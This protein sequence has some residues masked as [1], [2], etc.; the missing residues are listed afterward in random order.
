MLGAIGSILGVVAGLAVPLAA[1]WLVRGVE[2]RVSALSAALAFLFSCAVTILFG[3]VP[4]S[5]AAKLNPTEALRY[6]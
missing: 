3:V 6:E 2:V 4:A 5:R 1:R